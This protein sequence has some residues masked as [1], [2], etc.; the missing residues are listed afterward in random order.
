MFWTISRRLMASLVAFF[1]GWGVFQVVRPVERLRAVESP[2]I[3][4]LA[5]TLKAKGCADA[6]LECRVYDATFWSDG[7]GTYVGYANVDDWKGTFKSDFEQREFAYLVEQ[8]ERHRFFELP[9]YYASDSVEETVVLEVLTNEGLRVVT[10]H[11]WRSTP[12]ELR[13]IQ[14]LIDHQICQTGWE[15]VE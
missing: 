4:I 2:G 11:N 9:D 1:V 3:Q 5:I 8:L 14:A 10:T 13:V 7:T 6:E 12:N 15:R